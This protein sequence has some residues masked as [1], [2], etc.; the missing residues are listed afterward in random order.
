MRPARVS[1]ADEKLNPLTVQRRTVPV[2]SESERRCS[3]P[4][5]D[6]E[7]APDVAATRPENLPIKLTRAGGTSDTGVS[8]RSRLFR[9]ARSVQGAIRSPTIVGHAFATNPVYGVR[10][11]VTERTDLCSFFRSDD[12][13]IIGVSITRT[14]GKIKIVFEKHSRYGHLFT[15]FSFYFFFF[16]TGVV[17]INYNV[18][19]IVDY[20]LHP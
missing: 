15:I 14:D 10:D 13:R 20:N 8:N 3:A 6:L 9:R 5:T 19:V 7:T 12:T 1:C 11:R 16:T 4:P 18:R 2:G 17:T